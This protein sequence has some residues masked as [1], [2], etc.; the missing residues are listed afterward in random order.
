MCITFPYISFSDLGL[1]SKFKI[2]SDSSL[3]NKLYLVKFLY[4]IDLCV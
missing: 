4:G 1:P 3:E 2:I